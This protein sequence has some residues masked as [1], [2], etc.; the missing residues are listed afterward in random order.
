MRIRLIAFCMVLMYFMCIN[1]TM[2]ST[3]APLSTDES[4]EGF[5]TEASATVDVL[6]LKFKA[7]PAVRNFDVR[8][9]MPK[10]RLLSKVVVVTY[11]KNH[12]N[13]YMYE[14]VGG[15]LPVKV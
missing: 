1:F 14:L 3:Q 9:A 15:A 4:P 12:L 5:Y 10:E 13:N 6:V 7:L 8:I 11:Y 2:A